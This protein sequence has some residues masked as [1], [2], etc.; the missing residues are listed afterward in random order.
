MTHRDFC[1]WL[2]GYFEITDI[3]I[4]SVPTIGEWNTIVE[5][6]TLT[7]AR[8]DEGTEGSFTVFVKNLWGFVQIN[9]RQCPGADQWKQIKDTVAGL[10][11][12]VTSEPYERTNDA[13]TPKERADDAM[14]ANRILELIRERRGKRKDVPISPWDENTPICSADSVTGRKLCS[15]DNGREAYCCSNIGFTPDGAW[16][17]PAYYN[18]VADGQYPPQCNDKLGTDPLK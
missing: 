18:Y 13:R 9:G 16:P 14:N 17:D 6:L 7:I 8:V 2:Q 10:F 12:K 1:Y 15:S 5:H 4:G 3:V 11:E